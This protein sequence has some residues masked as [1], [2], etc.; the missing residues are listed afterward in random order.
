M[1]ELDNKEGWMSKNWCFWALV[2]EKTL[3]NPLD[4]KEIQTVHPKGNQSWIFIGR[5]YAKAEAPILWPPDVR[6]DSLEKTLMLGKIEGRRKR[7]NRG[8]SGWMV[9]LTQWT[10]VWAS[11]GRWWR[12]G[13]PGVLQP[14][15][16]QKVGHDWVT[17][18]QLSLHDLSLHH[19]WIYYP[20]SLQPYTYILSLDLVE[21]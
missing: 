16:L 19:W 9:S 15:G 2:L 17:E 12:T 1:W 18:Q 3:E 5:T 11:S 13:K 4:C 6:A 7:N 21:T 14:I 20:P 10:W 8:Q